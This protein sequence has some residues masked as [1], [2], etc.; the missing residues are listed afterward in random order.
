MVSRAAIYFQIFLTTSTY[1]LKCK[2]F[3][4]IETSFTNQNIEKKNFERKYI[5]VI[6]VAI[7]V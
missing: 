2:G 4:L 6:S 5:H 3:H 7:V 1:D